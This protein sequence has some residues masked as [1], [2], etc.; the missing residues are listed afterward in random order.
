MA[1]FR[2]SPTLLISV[3]VVV[4]F[5]L[6]ILGLANVN[7]VVSI[8]SILAS[9]GL[10]IFAASLVGKSFRNTPDRPYTN[11]K[12]KSNRP[13]FSLDYGFPLSVLILLFAS[14]NLAGVMSMASFNV[15]SASVV[16]ALFLVVFFLVLLSRVSKLSELLSGFQP[17]L[18]KK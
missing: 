6:T 7:V 12:H 14:L 9:T 4:S 3:L 10:A 16:S 15:V 8:G 2:K 17:S 13:D 18:P 11:A 1:N 5:F